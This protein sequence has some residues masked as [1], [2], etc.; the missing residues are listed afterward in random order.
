MTSRSIFTGLRVCV[1]SGQ[2]R[3]AWA[4]GD[5]TRVLGAGLWRD[6][7]VKPQ[8]LPEIHGCAHVIQEVPKVYPKPRGRHVK[9]VDPNVLVGIAAKTGWLC[10]RIAPGATYVPIFPRDWKGTTNGDT[11]LEVIRKRLKPDEL[12]L[13]AGT[14]V[15]DSLLHNVIDAMGMVLWTQKRL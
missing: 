9:R 4:F 12:A 10:G 5:G 2:H 6:D 15:C 8:A 13:L 11:F 3:I 7:L 14:G 1:D